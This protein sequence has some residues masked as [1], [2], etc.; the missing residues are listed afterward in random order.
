M[1]LENFFMR[2]LGFQITVNAVTS[3]VYSIKST[4]NRVGTDVGVVSGARTDL[5]Q[6]L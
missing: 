2:S 4:Y 5:C 6:V 1:T 3:S